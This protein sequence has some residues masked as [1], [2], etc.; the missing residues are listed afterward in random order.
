MDMTKEGGR[1]A[2][3][4]ASREPRPGEYLAWRVGGEEYGLDIRKVQI[5]KVQEIRS[6]EAPTRIPQ[7]PAHLKGVVNLRGVIVPVVDLRLRLGREAQYTASTVVIV[8][9]VDRRVAGIVVDSVSDVVDLAP[10]AIRPPPELAG[11]DGPRFITGVANV[12]ERMLLLADMDA[13]LADTL[14][15]A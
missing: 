8:L 6:Y 3:E 2:R 13:L 14:G 10:E 15:A 1:I 4:A 9:S 5:R 7:A 11:Q 12:G